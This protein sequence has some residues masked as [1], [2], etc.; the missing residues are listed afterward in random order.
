MR[1][2]L[3]CAFVYERVWSSECDPLTFCLV[4][5]N[6]SS[7]Q[8]LQIIDLAD[9]CFFLVGSA[10]IIISSEPLQ[11]ACFLVQ[12]VHVSDYYPGDRRFLLLG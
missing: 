3:T 12:E 8:V 2:I 4:L 11:Q 9:R 10:D 7:L 5:Q 1:R 6:R